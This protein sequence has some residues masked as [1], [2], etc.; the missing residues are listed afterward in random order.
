VRR[1]RARSNPAASPLWLLL[2]FV[3]I[4]VASY[5]FFT[6]RKP[7]PPT[8]RATIYYTKADGKT[9]ASY[10]VSLRPPQP[11][12]TA[13]DRLQYVVLYAATQAVAGPQSSVAA[14][15]F[16]VGTHVRAANV[17]GST[18]VVDLSGDVKNQTGGSLSETG[19]FKALVWTLTAIP[20]IDA[21]SVK[22]DGAK[23]DTLPGGHLA[24][25]TPLRR[26]DW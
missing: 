17:K 24:L 15:R 11:T 2:A 18:A 10:S 20:G 5:V 25:D 3:V 7:A 19:E 12:E 23:V 22:V 4:V 13:D 21:V 8:D 9:L 14:V 6:H 26:S 1:S 16:P